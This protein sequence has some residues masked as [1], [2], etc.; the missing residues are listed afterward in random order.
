MKSTIQISAT[1]PTETRDFIQSIADKDKRS[2]SE[3][4]SVLLQYAA[5]EKTRPRRG[6]KKDHIPDNSADAC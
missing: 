2:F 5:K 3:T 4:V 1:I 6:S